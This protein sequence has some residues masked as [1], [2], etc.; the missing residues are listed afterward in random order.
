M[1]PKVK[2]DTSACDG[3]PNNSCVTWQEYH[4]FRNRILRALRNYGTVGPMGEARITEDE[5]GP[6]EPWSVECHDPDFFVVDDWYNDW[7]FWAKVETQARNVSLA[8]M[9]S[10][11]AVLR[12]MPVNWAIG[13]SIPRRGYILLF[14]DRFMVDGPLLKGDSDLADVVLSCRSCTE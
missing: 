6:P 4:G 1:I 2:Y 10:L 11:V 7:S 3:D 13:I 12:E 14:A 9:E 5:T 8:V